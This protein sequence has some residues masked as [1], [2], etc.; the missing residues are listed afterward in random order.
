M[1][2]HQE[3]HRESE[4][5]VIRHGTEEPWEL[6]ISKLN[7]KKRRKFSL[8]ILAEALKSIDNEEEYNTTMASSIKNTIWCYLKNNFEKEVKKRTEAY[9][10][11]INDL[12]IELF[13]LANSVSHPSIISNSLWGMMKMNI[14]IYLIFNIY[15]I[16]KLIKNP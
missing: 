12:E 6:G 7:S 5:P 16:I 4:E 11:K 8:E 13:K 3:P 1:T 2:N 9:E 15:L 10:K 14:K